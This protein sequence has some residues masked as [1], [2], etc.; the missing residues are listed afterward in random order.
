MD[1]NGNKSGGAEEKALRDLRRAEGDLKHAEEEVKEA[2]EELEEA[3]RDDLVTITVD[4][5]LHKVR[6]GKWRVSD[7]K[8]KVGVDPA[9]VLAEITPQGLK[10]LDD[11]AEI[12][13]RANEKFM[14]HARSGGSS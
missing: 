2:L 8:A 9:K 5:I 4:G 13:V 1:N 10:D 3:K 7:L 11:N 14:S 12:E 6:R